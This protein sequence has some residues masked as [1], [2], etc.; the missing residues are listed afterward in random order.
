MIKPNSML[1]SAIVVAVL[2]LLASP[3]T[4]AFGQDE[5]KAKLDKRIDI[6]KP[7]EATLKDITEFLADR[8]DVRIVFDKNA[9]AQ[10]KVQ[11]P[12]TTKV[13]LPKMPNAM[14]DS[15]L[16]ISLAQAKSVYEIRGKDVVIVPSTTDGKP[17]PFPAI[18]D[19]RKKA[20][21]NQRGRIAK[22]K[23]V[24][25]DKPAETTIGDVIDFLSDWSDIAFVVDTA[26]F[27][28]K[29]NNDDVAGTRIKLPSMKAPLLSVL[30]KA[31]DQVKGTFELHGDH[32]RIVPAAGPES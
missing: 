32:I 1:V 24:D 17:R 6:D 31:L 10:A 26:A 3:Q 27:K 7:I 5:V 21:A 16:R 20:T 8:F 18:S 12:A 2:V 30:K 13:R 23:D 25:I 9:F 19:A 11:D 22:L 28:G 29:T 14:L 4:P 15:I